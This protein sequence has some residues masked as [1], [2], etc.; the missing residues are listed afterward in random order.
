MMMEMSTALFGVTVGMWPALLLIPLLF[1]GVW[2]KT[3]KHAITKAWEGEARVTF[4]S[5]LRIFLPRFCF[6]LASILIVLAMADITRSFVV[7]SE[8]L[9]V[10]RLIVTLDNSSSMYNFKGSDP[11]PIRCTDKQLKYEFPRIWNACRA[12]SQLID[13]TE[14]YAKKK[15]EQRQD[16]IALLRFGLNSFVEVY[17]T[18]DYHRV[19]KV[20]SELNWRDPR[21]GVFTEIHLALWDMFQ[22]AL[23]KNFRSAKGSVSFDE[24]DRHAL[25]RSLYPEGL[26]VRYHQPTDIK[27]KLIELRKDLSDTAFII[28]TDAHEGQFDGRLDKPPVS[29]VKM[30]QLAEYLEVPVYVISI[31]ADHERIRKLAEKTGKGP[32]GGSGR[33]AF[34]LLKGEKNYE[35]M[36]VIISDILSARFHVDSTHEEVQRESYTSQFAMC[37][38]IFLLLGTILACTRFG[39]MLTGKDGGKA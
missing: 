20:M 34:Y 11:A 28:I 10:N 33:G 24:R 30:M 16:K 14:A 2:G 36:D 19:R 3:E 5:R 29:L 1:L 38:A 31:N 4:F 13:A 32:I 27:S 37:A 26:D 39:R 18:S 7:V 12:M 6:A 25:L 22:V 15:G 9:A 23:Q 35:H 21:T 8:Q 17:G